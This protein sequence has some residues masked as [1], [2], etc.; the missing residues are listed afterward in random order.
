MFPHSMN[1]SDRKPRRGAR[2]GA[3]ALLGAMLLASSGLAATPL[4]QGAQDRQRSM[5]V[6]VTDQNGAPVSG[7]TPTDFTVREDGIQREVLRVEPATA[8][9]EITLLVDTSDAASPYIA[10]LRRALTEFVKETAKGNEMA[11]TAFGARPQVMQSYT[12]SP[13]LLDRAIG[14]L[15]PEQGTGA[16]LLEALSSVASGITKR[17]PERAAIIAIIVQAGPEFSSLS[18]EPVVKALRD[19]GAVFDAVTLTTAVSSAVSAAERATA[20]HDREVVL[21]QGTRATGGTNEQALSGMALTPELRAI[22]AQ[23]RNQYR[24]VYARPESLIPPEKIEVAVKKPGLTAR[25]TP[26]KATRSTQRQQE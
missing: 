14:R 11:L 7:L 19:C 23:L 10:D 5:Y 25:G 21:D 13:E 2:I 24:L 26:V 22:S 18:Y 4:A 16:Y 3:V 1:R 15:F 12:R 8:P 9:I 20:M 6:T 17:A